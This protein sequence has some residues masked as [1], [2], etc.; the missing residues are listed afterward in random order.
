MVHRAAISI[1]KTL[2]PSNAL[3]HTR[4]SSEPRAVPNPPHLPETGL[5][6]KGDDPLTT[7][8]ADRALLLRTSAEDGLLSG[9]LTVTFNG[10]TTVLDADARRMGDRECTSALQALPNID[11]V[12]CTRRAVSEFGGGDFLISLLRYA[13]GGSTLPDAGEIRADTDAVPLRTFSVQD[14]GKC[15]A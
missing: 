4:K 5:C 12:A 14:S 3:M 2:R 11:R 9:E 15:F 7:D 1:C 6:P 10:E 8:Q 13:V